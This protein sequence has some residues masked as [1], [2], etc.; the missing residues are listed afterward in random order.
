MPFTFSHPAAVLPLLDAG[1]RGRGRLVATGL[2]TGSMAPDVPFFLDTVV[3]GSYG[4]GRLAHRPWAVPTLNV[5]LAAGL[6]A[7]WRGAV[8]ESVLSVLPAATAGRLDVLTAPRRK[9]EPADAVWFAASAAVG[10]LTHLVWDAF[11]HDGRAGVRAF[12]VLRRRIL[13]TPAHHALQWGTSAVGLACLGVAGVRVLR[14][15]EPESEPVPQSRRAVKRAALGMIS[16]GTLAGALVR[17]RRDRP[18]TPADLVASATFGGGAGA[19]LA[20][21]LLPTLT[22]MGGH[23]AEPAPRRG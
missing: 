14:R 1:G 17:I 2:V 12:P 20:T 6:A 8:R 18:R 10:A 16:T 23:D 9:P 4:L 19:A 22:S 13:G 15:T 3:P 7:A 5:A 11:T 21:A